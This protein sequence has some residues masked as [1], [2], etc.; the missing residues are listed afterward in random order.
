VS[1]GSVEERIALLALRLEAASLLSDL[2]WWEP[3]GGLAEAL[4]GAL[5]GSGSLSGPEVARL[6]LWA[7]RWALVGSGLRSLLRTGGS[8][9]EPPEAL[10][11]SLWRLLAHPERVLSASDRLA[12]RALHRSLHGVDPAFEIEPLLPPLPRPP[13]AARG[14]S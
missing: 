8:L 2:S 5:R 14:I 6:R 11:R 1:A 7:S 4:S 3:V 12:L 13:G 10:S 9:A